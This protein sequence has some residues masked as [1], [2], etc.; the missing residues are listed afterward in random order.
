MNKLDVLGLL[1]EHGAIEEGHFR[2]PSGLHSPIFIQTASVM[3]YPYIAQRIARAMSARFPSPI[4][5]VL[6]PAVGGVVAG[7]EIA[8]LRRC[9]SIFA[10][11]VGGE[12]LLRRE[13]K[14][15]PGERVLVVE[16]VLATGHLAGA[17]V[18][19]VRAYGGK[20][21][22]IAAILDRSTAA[23]PLGVPVR[24]LVTYPVQVMPPDTC[25]LCARRVPFSRRGALDILDDLG[26][27]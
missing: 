5:V 21:V 14:I 24:A 16:D 10:E 17:V 27:P 1:Q 15:V 9:R 18:E 11:R 12:M 8:R 7:Q 2:L 25:E 22:G 6:A 4:D 13:F 20:V 26:S 3:Q 19:L 23:L